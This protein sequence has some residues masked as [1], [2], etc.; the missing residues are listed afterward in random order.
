M[1]EK[2]PMPLNS[3][4]L[5]EDEQS[6]P[7]EAS[8]ELGS[9]SS[10]A[11]T[12]VEEAQQ[13]A[14]EAVKDD[15]REYITGYKLGMVV[16]GVTLVCFLVLLDTSIIVTVSQPHFNLTSSP[17]FSNIFRL[18]PRL[19]HTFTPWKTWDGTEAHIRLLGTLCRLFSTCDHHALTR[20]AVLACNLWLARSI[21][22]SAQK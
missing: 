10:S 22:T 15:E 17:G 13:V 2:S 20:R 14:P 21:P 9:D 8:K 18:F 1:T 3:F 16:V 12:A 6:R 7:Q 5:S 11:S 4:T 19:Q